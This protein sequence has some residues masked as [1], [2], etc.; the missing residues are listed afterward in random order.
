MVREMGKCME[1]NKKLSHASMEL[2]FF[3]YS[4]C[5]QDKKDSRIEH[6]FEEKGGIAAINQRK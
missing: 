3:I 4:E 2:M 5:E 6:F 1:K